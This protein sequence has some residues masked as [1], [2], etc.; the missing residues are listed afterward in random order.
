MSKEKNGGCF[1]YITDYTTQLHRDYFLKHHC[2]D[3][4]IN[5]P[6][7]QVR[8]PGFGDIPRADRTDHPL[9]KKKNA[10]ALGNFEFVF[11]GKF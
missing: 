8:D 10:S 6:G 7:F 2:K 4:V 11:V 3:P 1:G 9:K 5:Q